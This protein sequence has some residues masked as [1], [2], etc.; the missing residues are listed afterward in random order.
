MNKYKKIARERRHVA[1]QIEI[2]EEMDSVE[3]HQRIETYFKEYFKELDI[4][5]YWGRCDEFAAEL[6]RRWEL[7]R[8]KRE[9]E[10][11]EAEHAG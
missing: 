7:Y 11:E 4:Q 10:R 8:Q 2:I 1:V 5:V 6:L 3:Q 9:K